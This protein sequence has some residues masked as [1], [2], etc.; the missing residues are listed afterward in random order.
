VTLRTLRQWVREHRPFAMLTCYDATTAGWLWRGGVRCLL[1]GDTAAQMILGYDSTLPA[2]MPFMVEITAAV[3][4]GAPDAFVMADMPFGSYQGGDDLAVRNAVAFMAQGGADAVKLEVDASFAPLVERLSHAGVPVVAHL[5]SRPQQVRAL[6]GY[7]ATGR[8][9]READVVVEAAERM[10]G[11]GAAMLLLEA[12]PDELS[13]RVVHAATSGAAAPGRPWP[14]PVVGCGGGPSCH[15]HVVVLQDLLGLS[16][17]QPAFARPLADVG[18]QVQAA[19]ERWSL[20]V[21]SGRYLRDDHPYHM[22][23]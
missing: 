17:W 2:T 3:R 18:A 12:V 9:V 14:V 22:R 13:Q 5:G 11:A 1:V 23:A 10:L 16:T 6:G 15:G 20:L 21:E 8:T 19:A 4:R 7:H